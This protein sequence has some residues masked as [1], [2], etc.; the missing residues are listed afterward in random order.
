MALVLINPSPSFARF[1][2]RNNRLANTKIGGNLPLLSSICTYLFN[3]YFIKLG[4][5][6]FLPSVSSAVCNSIHHIVRSATP[7][8]ILK[9]VIRP[10]SILMSHIKRTRL[11]G[12]KSGKHKPM[13][14]VFFYHMADTKADYQIAV[15]AQKRFQSTMDYCVSSFSRTSHIAKIRNFIMIFVA[16]NFFPNFHYSTH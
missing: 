2:A 9:C 11:L 13:N 14:G 5:M 1:Y 3:R 15:C 16:N 8:E 12:I 10:A 4:T 7:F 6:M